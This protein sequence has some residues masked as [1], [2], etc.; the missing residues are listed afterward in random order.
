MR[1]SSKAAGADFG[2]IE[3][4]AIPSGRRVEGAVRVPPSKS[5]THRVLNLALL[6]E[7]PLIVESPLIADDTRLFLAALEACGWGVE[8]VEQGERGM[9]EVR[10]VPGARGSNDSSPIEIFC[11]NAGTMY[12]FLVATLVAIPGEYRLDGMPRLRERPIGP[13]VD[14]VRRLGGEIDYLGNEGYGPLAIRG[15]TLRGGTTG[16]D[17]GSSSQYLSALLM[18]GLRAKEPTVVELSALTSEP[19]V[20]IT[21][22]WVR[23]F[24]GRAERLA[25]DR[26]RVE[27]SP[28]L[29][30]GL[31]RVRVEGD[32][33]A[34]AYP[35]AMAAL[36]RGTVHLLGIDRDSAQGD[37]AFVDLLGTMGAEVAWKGEN[38]RV[39]GTGRLIG[40]SVDLGAM[41]DQVPTLAALAPFS[42]GTTR[43]TGVPHLRIKESDRLHAMAVGL[44]ALGVPVRE[45]PDGLEI[46]GVWAGRDDLPIETVTIDPFDD[47]RIAMS[48][49]LLGLRRPGVTI[50]EPGVVA[51]SYPD[52]WRDFE[53]LT[54]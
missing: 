48:F 8:A 14:A 26:F 24:G 47:H 11:G 30:V 41:P 9:D 7:R 37:R 16:L 32:W 50:A 18:A 49:A 6:A 31:D 42:E 43:I 46:E 54:S 19:Y 44:A 12:R 28:E 36:C 4:R 15:G 22:D 27:P 29:G 1:D 17:A 13:L 34:A 23:R 51:K 21:L 40:L 52:F 35:A 2:T 45:L 38:L 5:V 10:L 53:A 25:P 20:D 39:S 33:S 3:L